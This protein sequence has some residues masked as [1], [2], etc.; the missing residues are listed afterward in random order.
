M[1][2]LLS[3]ASIVGGFFATAILVVIGTAL[4]TKIFNTQPKP[5]GPAIVPLPYLIANLVLSLLAAV[6]GGYVCRRI[7]P[8]HPF[9]HVI[10]LA[11][12]FEALSL[13]TAV[14]T[15]AE[16]GQPNW[17]PWVIGLICVSG[18]LAGGSI[19]KF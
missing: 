17:Y 10:V 15:G 11:G 9:V 1:R 13:T 7:A 19:R 6:A 14:T 8:N 5:D 2:T 4:A 18:I 3:I 12:L 16:P